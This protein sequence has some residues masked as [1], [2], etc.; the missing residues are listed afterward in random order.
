MLRILMYGRFGRGMSTYLKYFVSE[1][2]LDL[3][4]PLALQYVLRLAIENDIFQCSIVIVL[5]IG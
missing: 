2:M 3:V 1:C 5:K 4:S